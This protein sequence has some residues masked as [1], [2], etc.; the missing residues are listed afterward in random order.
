[1]SSLFKDAT[2]EQLSM[3]LAVIDRLHIVHIDSMLRWTESETG[4]V[5]LLDNE[6]VIEFLISTDAMW[7][8]DH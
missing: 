6:E 7:I 2:K 4:W 1:M 5:T 8:G 3:L